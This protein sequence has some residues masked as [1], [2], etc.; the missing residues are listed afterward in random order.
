MGTDI[1]VSTLTADLEQQFID[2]LG[3]KVEVKG[4]LETGIVSISY[5]SRADLDMLY[6][7]LAAK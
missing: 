3:T 7:K 2:A 6:D 4:D 1:Y 5:F